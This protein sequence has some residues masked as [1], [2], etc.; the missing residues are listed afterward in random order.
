MLDMM[1]MLESSRCMHNQ[2]A[3]SDDA[4]DFVETETSGTLLPSP[5]R[6]F[7][8]ITLLE[9]TAYQLL[10]A[11]RPREAARNGADGEMSRA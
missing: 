6:R 1:A 10:L 11:V 7:R 8:L 4:P 2:F 9:T 5:A 3:M